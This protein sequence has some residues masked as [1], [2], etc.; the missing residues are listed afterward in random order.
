MG[1]LSLPLSSSL[2]PAMHQALILLM[3][4]WASVSLK[5]L[6]QDQCLC[7]GCTAAQVRM[8]VHPATSL[9]NS[10]RPHNLEVQCR[11]LCVVCGLPVSQ[12]QPQ[13][14]LL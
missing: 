10:Q 13:P 14:V 6:E 4:C 7:W 12:S 5:G 2:A 8:K 9:I 3:D 11:F 1:F